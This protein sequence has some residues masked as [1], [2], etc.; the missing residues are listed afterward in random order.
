MSGR[1]LVSLSASLIIG[2]ACVAAVATDASA[3]RRG[4]AAVA[5]GGV[6]H[7]GVARAGAY[8]GGVA[9]AGVY[10]GGVARAGVYRRGVYGAPVARAAA[11]G[12]GA[13]AVGAAA[14]GGYGQYSAPAS[15]SYGY[16]YS[17]DLVCQPGTFFTGQ[18][19]LQ[20]PCQ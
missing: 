2:I 9:R 5:R 6:H 14:Y 15:S 13:A 8:R 4:G 19:G 7:A 12:L 11:V 17:N 1:T 16:G 20:H 10:R 18:D 3:Y